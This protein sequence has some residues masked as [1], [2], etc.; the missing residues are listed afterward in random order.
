VENVRAFRATAQ[1]P[2][3]RTQF[4]GVAVQL[5]GNRTSQTAPP[6]LAQLSLIADGVGLGLVVPQVLRSSVS[7]RHIKQQLR[8]HRSNNRLFVQGL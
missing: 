2:H 8:T 5:H 7:R 4:A 3:P 1:S 6:A